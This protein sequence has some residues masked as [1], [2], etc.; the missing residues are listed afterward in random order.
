[1][2]S[3]LCVISYIS[4]SIASFVKPT[5][6]PSSKNFYD[7]LGRPDKPEDYNFKIGQYDQD[8]SYA[9]FKES[10]YNNGLTRQTLY[11]TPA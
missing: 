10:A 7:K 8:E 5:A 11:P 1:M 6:P 9:A 3:G 4:A 2:Y